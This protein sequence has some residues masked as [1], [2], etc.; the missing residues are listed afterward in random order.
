MCACAVIAGHNSSS[1][2]LDTLLSP[3]AMIMLQVCALF[4]RGLQHADMFGNILGMVRRPHRV[5]KTSKHMSAPTNLRCSPP[6]HPSP[7]HH[8]CSLLGWQRWWCCRLLSRRRPPCAAA[9]ASR[10]RVS[11]EQKSVC[12][13]QLSGRRALLFL[14]LPP[15]PALYPKAP[16]LIIQFNPPPPPISRQSRSR[17]A[18]GVSDGDAGANRVLP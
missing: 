2:H 14:L 13:L 4:L 17:S 3:A 1:R 7:T 10:F 12:K 5:R 15:H 6:P 11:V 18:T 16:A 9:T 8:M